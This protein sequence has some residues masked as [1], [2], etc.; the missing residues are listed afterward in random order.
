MLSHIK[1]SQG[2]W[3]VVTDNKSYQFGPSHPE[4]MSLV[5]CV[6]SG[7]A[8]QMVELID[9]GS[10]IENW[11]NGSFRFQDGVLYYVDEQVHSAITNRIVE[12]IKQNFDVDPILNFLKRLYQNPSYRA[13]HELY[14]FLSHKF[15]PITPEGY[16]LAYKAVKR[17]FTDKYSGKMNN[18]VGEMVSMPRFRVDDNCDIG[19]S[20][21]LHVGAIDYV[22]SYGSAGDKVVICK[23]DPAD[24]VSVPLDSDHQKLRCCK[25]EVVGEYDGEL[26]PAVVEDYES[27]S[28]TRG[29]FEYN[30]EE[31][32]YDKL[33]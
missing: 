7:D 9:T 16:F 11:S 15:L 28:D 22:K 27:E 14:E 13:I 8:T 20:Q 32:D 21:G 24:V 12:M 25:Y 18:S 2:N 19:C 17:D 31:P 29:F 33:D 30:Y 4:Y 3:T 5:E 26:L 10:K 1:D 23:I 6:R